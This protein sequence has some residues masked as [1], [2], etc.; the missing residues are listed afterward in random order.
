[1]SVAVERQ[2]LS[3]TVCE[4]EVSTLAMTAS[5]MEKGSMVYATNTMNRKKDT[6]GPG[7]RKRER[8]RGRERARLREK[9]RER[10]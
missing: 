2:T 9:E 7:E 5:R 8:E 6:C 3:T 10:D 4:A 1:M